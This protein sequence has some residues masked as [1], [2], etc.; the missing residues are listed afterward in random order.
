VTVEDA[1]A[2]PPPVISHGGGTILGELDF[3]DERDWGGTYRDRH[4]VDLRAG[5]LVRVDL[6]SRD[7][8]TV[9]EVLHEGRSVAR[10]DDLAA[11]IR[12]SSVYF[13]APYTGIYEVIATSYH[14]G[15]TGRYEV[16]IDVDS[17]SRPVHVVT[18]APV[19]LPTPP[20]VVTPRPVHDVRPPPPVDHRPPP[21][22]GGYLPDHPRPPHRR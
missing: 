22:H 14:S 11:G 7:F 1:W 5:D 4:F 17:R 3:R 6:S 8:D 13:E 12:D 10:N 21:P 2:P 16:R 9:L 15:A 19:F 18:P 20:I